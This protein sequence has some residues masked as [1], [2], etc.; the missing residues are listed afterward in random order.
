MRVETDADGNWLSA[1]PID[2]E[3]AVREDPLR[4]RMVRIVPDDQVQVDP[5]L[6]QCLLDWAQSTP[7]PQSAGSS[8]FELQLS[9]LL[10][11]DKTSSPVQGQRGEPEISVGGTLDRRVDGALTQEEVDAVLQAHMGQIRYCYL[12][13]LVKQ[14]TLSGSLTV[15]FVVQ[16]DGSVTKVDVQPGTLTDPA[17][18]TCMEGRFLRMQYPEPTDG[19]PV[20]VH[21]PLV[22]T[23]S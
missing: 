2:H 5:A 17:V 7:L 19:E 6:D 20:L 3:Q 21:V 11:P 14:N 10:P 4:E 16:P 13:V 18:L 23:S 12:R 1:T 8:T 9:V 22:F 15:D